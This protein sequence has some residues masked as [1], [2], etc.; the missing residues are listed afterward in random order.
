MVI[1]APS[2]ANIPLTD[3]GQQLE[4]LYEGG[5]RFFHIDLMDGH[6][7]KS[8][9]F[10]VSV[11]RD[12][13]ERYPDVTIEVHMMV[14]NP[15]D[16][17]ETLKAYGA[18]YVAFHIDSTSFVRRT[19]T[20]I[21]AAGMKAGVALNPSQR[22]DIIEP[23]AHLIDYC[24]FMGVEPGFAGQIFLP[25]SGKRLVELAEFR[26]EHNCG[27]QILVDGGVTNEIAE[28]S[29][30]HGADI[31]VT[32]IFITFRQDCGIVE[33]CQRFEKRMVKLQSEL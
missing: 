17:I 8:L 2:L 33:A 11:V 19:I 20:T 4:E 6:Y 1:N 28:E 31:L 9:C 32:G 22:I 18:E 29:V 12:V 10:P 24:V 21:K 13:K 3:F 7:V 30:K 25:D 5:I 27:F 16:Y 15:M 26:K 14:D 23:Y